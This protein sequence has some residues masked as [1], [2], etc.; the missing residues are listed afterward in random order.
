MLTL[1]ELD[2][3]EGSVEC[4][5][6]CPLLTP[7]SYSKVIGA[8]RELLS[9]KDITTPPDSDRIVLACLFDRP[10]GAWDDDYC[11]LAYYEAGQW[12]NRATH[13][14]IDIAGWKELPAA[15]GE[16]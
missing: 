7:S 15:P 5:G 12:Y 3:I 4:E 11:V 16:L 13:G 1:T 9:R 6:G 8:L 10:Q 14:R 2:A